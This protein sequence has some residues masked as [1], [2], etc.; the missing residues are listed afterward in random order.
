MQNHSENIAVEKLS[1]SIERI[2]FHNPE[3]GF[4][5]LKI[6]SP[7]RKELI[8]VVGNATT[9][10]VGEYIEG[11]GTWINDK[12]YGLQFK[13]AQLTI[14]PPTT[15]D[16]IE[17]YLASGMVK[18]I[19]PHFARV[20][21]KAFGNEIFTILDESPKKLLKLPGIGQKR[22]EMI[23]NS[24]AEQKAIRHIMVF[25]QSHG[26]GSARA[27]R[28]YKTYGNEAIE[29]IRTNPYQLAADI[30]GI[31]F[32]TADALALKLGID[33]HSPTRAQAGISYVLQNFTNSG[34]CATEQEMLV[35]TTSE[36]LEIPETIIEQAI[37]TE[38]AAENVIAEIVNDK[39]CLFLAS[40]YYAEHSIA[41]N[42]G[43]ISVGQP[44]WNIIE[45]EKAI[46]WVENR[47][48][49]KLSE[50]QCQAVKEAIKEKILIITGGPGVGKTTIIK[51][52]LHIV[53]AKGVGVALCAPTGR[54]AKRLAEAT[55]LTAKTIHRLLEYDPNSHSFRRDQNNPLPIDMLVV[56]E[57]SMID[58]VLMH[59]LLKAVPTHAAVLIVGDIDQLPSV[60]PGAVLN[61]MIAA[62]T[63]PVIRL[64]EIFRQAANSKIIVN[65]HRINNGLF[66]LKET[67][68][69]EASDFYIIS[70][71]TPEEIHDKLLNIVT[72]SIPKSFGFNPRDIQVLTP[73]NRGGLGARSLNVSLQA[74][75]NPNAAPKINRFGWTFAPNDKV[76]QNINDYDKEVFNGDIGRIF[77]INIEESTVKIDFDG[78]L[79][80]YDFNELDAISLA[81]ATSIHKSQGSEYPVVVIPIA[82]Q[83]YMLLARNL[84]YTAMTRGKKLVVIIC[85]NKALAMAIKNINIEPRITNLS[86][87]LKTL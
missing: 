13:A 64:T 51:S 12:N 11:T 14:S 82:M 43:K 25:L 1:G 40:L 45:S 59:H 48:H 84:L 54:A 9:L 27:V 85:Q 18:G 41:K 19:G 67:A 44:P 55:G 66:P 28:I 37:N 39:Q 57:A 53:R 3:N 34:H 58:V 29:K 63:I 77:S 15:L 23:V 7:H 33:K 70:A 83:H 17:K 22:K 72:E 10:G 75:L 56:D 16:G 20:L 4:C 8:T 81:Y 68:T 38:I 31:G 74:L 36:L 86:A 30:F 60:G 2:T 35:K 42:I 26:I 69:E 78:R 79:I 62:Q 52:I 47:T 80:E 65:A 76:I 50:S 5:V 71:G 61:D 46:A 49:I 87:R 24:W 21:I 32:K 73:M 6:K